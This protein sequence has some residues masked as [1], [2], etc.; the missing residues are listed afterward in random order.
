MRAPTRTV[1][2]KDLTIWQSGRTGYLSVPFTWLL[3]KAREYVLQ[4]DLFAKRWIVGGPAVR[5]MPWFFDGVPNVK[6]GDYAKGVLQRVNP[7]A[8]RTTVGCPRRCKFCGI[9]RRKIEGEFRELD[10]WPNL[11]VICDNNLLAA[12]VAH[13][14]IVIDRLVHWQWCDFNQGLDA[15]LLTPWH[16]EQ[17]ARITVPMVRLSLD[18]DADREAWTTAVDRLRTAGIAKKRIRTYVLC[19]LSGGPEADWARC[20]FVESFKLRALPQWYHPLDAMTYGAVTPEQEAMGWTKQ[21]QRHLMR[22]YYQHTGRPL[23]QGA[24]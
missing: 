17:I 19:G 1:W 11:P 9:G 5:L 8:T 3:P 7:M 12:N 18:S 22:Y 16:A 24:I 15:R 4:G 23:A 20:E 13:F 2:P 14:K 21:G 10:D 6:I